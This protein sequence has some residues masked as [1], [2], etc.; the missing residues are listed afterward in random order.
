MQ[1]SFLNEDE[2]WVKREVF[3]RIC[4]DSKTFFL[5]LDGWKFK[6]IS[7]KFIEKPF[8]RS[9]AE[10][11]VA[12]CKIIF[13]AGFNP[14]LA[15][16]VSDEMN[17]LF[18]ENVNP[19]DG[20]IEK[21][22]SVIASLA[23]SAFTLNLHKIFQNEFTAAFDSRII[24][25]FNEEEII[26]YLALRQMNNWRNHN[27]AYAYWIL[28]KQ[29]E[30]PA[31]ISKMLK[32]LKTSEL[33]KI[34]LQHGVDLAKTPKWQRRGILISKRSIKKRIAQHEVIRWKIH[35]NWNLPLFTSENGAKLIK[36][37]LEMTRK[38]GKEFGKA[39]EN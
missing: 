38:R 15:Y 5:R 7:E 35:E 9:F 4:V 24:V 11:M 18:L 6:K 31:E 12:S 27:N 13:N 39:T 25:I 34:M 21:I 10:C 30:K 26:E 16:I 28:R 17:F 8:D 14:A 3:S 37:I 20:R 23:S 22:N 33:H 29:G 19:F 1:E 32:G 2:K 36:Q